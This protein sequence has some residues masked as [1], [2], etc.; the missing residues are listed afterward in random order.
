MALKRMGIVSNY[1]EIR[2]HRIVTGGL[3]GS[4][5]SDMLTRIGVLILF[6]YDG[7]EPI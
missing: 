6:N 3:V 7:D 1:E 4:L 5:A 2:K